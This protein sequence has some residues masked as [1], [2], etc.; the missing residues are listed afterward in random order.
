MYLPERHPLN[1][2]DFYSMYSACTACGAPQAEAPELIAHGGD[3]DTCFFRRQPATEAELDQAIQAM[4]VA[5]TNALRYGGT[6]ERVLKRLYENG[7]KELC[8]H[9]PRQDYPVVI[10]NQVSFIYPGA[11]QEF[12]MGLKDHLL[13]RLSSVTVTDR[14]ACTDEHFRFIQRWHPE[15][16]GT[17]YE[18]RLE[19]DQR[20]GIWLRP[21]GNIPDR[22][23]GRGWILYEFL[24]QKGLAAGAH[25][26][27]LGSMDGV[28]YEKPF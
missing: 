13:R 17:I 19:E 9:K 2:G 8:D 12:V 27:E 24:Q 25:W 1:R 18:G 20:V 3:Y 23:V 11:L 4:M 16:R 7:M 26:R 22:E 28:V 5:C 10:R 6:D 14:I 21:E 15:Y